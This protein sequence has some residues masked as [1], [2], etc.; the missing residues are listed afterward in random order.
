MYSQQ[1]M[2]ENRKRTIPSNTPAF[3]S[4]RLQ[5]LSGVKDRPSLNH[6]DNDSFIGSQRPIHNHD[7]LTGKTYTLID[8][9]SSQTNSSSI[10]SVY[11]VQH[12]HRPNAHVSRLDNN[13]NK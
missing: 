9:E 11:S 6:N 1:G 3:P 4:K 12:P 7:S 13:S 5:R 8:T 2:N 10:I